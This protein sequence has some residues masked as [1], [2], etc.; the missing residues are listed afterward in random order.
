VARSDGGRAAP[1]GWWESLRLGLCPRLPS[2]D[3]GGHQQANS[4]NRGR[5]NVSPLVSSC[6]TG[7]GLLE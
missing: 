2:L 4:P 1:L 3:S 7:T 5:P 6:A